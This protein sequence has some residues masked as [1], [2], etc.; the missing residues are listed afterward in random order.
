MQKKSMQ[1][2]L[3][4][5]LPGYVFLIP[6]LVFFILFVVYPMFNGIKISMY[7]YTARKYNFVG[8]DN[9]KL[10]LSDAVFIKSLVNTGLI[11]LGNVPLVLVFSMIISIIIFDKSEFVRSFFRAAFYLPAVAS[12]VTIAIVWRWMYSP[13]GGVINYF[14][15]LLGIAPVNWLGNVKYALPALIVV[16]FTLSVGQPIILYIASLGN[17]PV[18]YLEVAEIDGASWWAKVL[19]IFWPLVKPTTL[20]I[21]II[22]T[23]NSFQTFALVQLLTGGG[24]MYRTSTILFSLYKSAFE[25]QNYGLASAMGIILSIIVVLI[26]V[27]QYKYLSTDIEY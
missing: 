20:Y 15:G 9:F 22:T 2:K 18:T 26:S 14:I 10:L 17:I 11:V 24:P 21:A 4:A 5:W 8:L 19:H 12:I 25:L 1:A 3:K 13:R 16:L 27:I 6:A 7:E 23:I